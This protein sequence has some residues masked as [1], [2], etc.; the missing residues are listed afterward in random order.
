MTIF[1]FN[2]VFRADPG[3]N[4]MSSDSDHGGGVLIAT[5]NYNT[6]KEE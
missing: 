2:K 3:R 1:T 4:Y 6:V 5:R